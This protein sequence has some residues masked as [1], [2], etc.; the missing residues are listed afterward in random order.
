MS[1]PEGIRIERAAAAE[2]EELKKYVHDTSSRV[3]RSLLGNRN[4][5][6][7]EIL[8]LLNRKNIQADILEAIARDK[9]WAESYPV[10]LALARNP[11]SPLSVSLSTAR[12]LR[13]FDLEEITRNH[14]IPLVF[15][16]K[17]E[18][19]LVERVP[20]MPLGNKKT[21]AKKAAG[22]VLLKLLQDRIPEVVALCLNNPNMVEGHLYKVIN[23]IDT[24]LET[25]L[26]IAEHPV[27]S[28]RPL[29]RFALV[30]NIN[31]PLTV[32]VRFLESM[33]LMDLRE[34]YRDPSLQ[35]TVKPFVHRELWDRGI[36]PE[37]GEEN[38]I[39]QIMGEEFSELDEGNMHELE[40]QD[41]ENG[42]EEQG[43]SL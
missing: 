18:R 19:M 5:T 28:C 15:R 26:M 3:L 12:F 10:R 25:I 39:Y 16:H 41:D 6:E 4:V 1:D 21:L 17:V 22:T 7:E 2:K 9:R 29:I 40:E 27:W 33:K 23:R 43:P 14:F 11:R 8:I 24:P 30:R 37:K 32:S 13:V 38:Q 34:L 20:T 42:S 35:V 31:T 36:D